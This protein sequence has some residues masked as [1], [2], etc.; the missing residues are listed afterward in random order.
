MPEYAARRRFLRK[1]RA[2]ARIAMA[3]LPWHAAAANGTSFCTPL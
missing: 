3:P 1:K 2:G